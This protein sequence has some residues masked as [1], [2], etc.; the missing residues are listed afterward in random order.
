[1]EHLHGPLAAVGAALERIRWAVALQA[2]AEIP[3]M[4]TDPG[5]IFAERLPPRLR[6]H[7]PD[8]YIAACNG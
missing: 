7:M 3:G 2:G 4:R 6:D 1:M 5:S 8:R